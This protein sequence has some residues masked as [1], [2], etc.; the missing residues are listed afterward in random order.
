MLSEITTQKSLPF[1]S[2]EWLLI[3]NDYW[4]AMSDKWPL[5]IFTYYPGFWS[6]RQSMDY[7]LYTLIYWAYA[8]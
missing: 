7:N 3:S 5:D 6:I 8:L 4:I 2:D 1:S